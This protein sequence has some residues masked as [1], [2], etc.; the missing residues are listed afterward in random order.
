MKTKEILKE[1]REF[2]SEGDLD[3][4]KYK[5]DQKVKVEICCVGC[6]D[7][8]STKSFKAEKGDKF[9][10]KVVAPNLRNRDVNFGGGD[11]STEVNFLL[12]KTE[13][14]GEQSFPQCC[15]DLGMKKN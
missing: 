6:A 14:K 5:E 12:I 7:A 2:L 11:K 8:A 3:S 10:G 9:S 15:V 13:S 1:W 4:V